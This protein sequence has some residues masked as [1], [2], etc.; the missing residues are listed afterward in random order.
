[1]LAKTAECYSSNTTTEV[2][3]IRKI[4][5]QY[6]TYGFHFRPLHA[7]KTPKELLYKHT[8]ALYSGFP[9]MKALLT[10][11]DMLLLPTYS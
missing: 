11:P 2:K 6:L 5:T 10:I 3:K 1:M 7:Q 4:N 8:V 9:L